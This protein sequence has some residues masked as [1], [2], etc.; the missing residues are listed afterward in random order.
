MSKQSYQLI[1]LVFFVQF[2]NITKLIRMLEGALNLSKPTR[3]M[4]ELF[5]LIVAF[6]YVLHVFACLW[7]WAG[8]YSHREW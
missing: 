3:S 4:L 5:K 8:D 2:K 7:F 6:M 1:L